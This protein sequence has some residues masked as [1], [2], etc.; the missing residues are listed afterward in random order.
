M[1]LGAVLL[2]FVIAIAVLPERHDGG[3]RQPKHF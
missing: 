3:P 1:I 2:L